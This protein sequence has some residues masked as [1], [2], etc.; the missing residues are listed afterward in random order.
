MIPVLRILIAVLF[1]GIAAWFIRYRYDGSE[2]SV[3]FLAWLVATAVSYALR[4][5]A[6]WVGDMTISRNFCIA[7]FTVLAA[8]LFLIFG[9]ARSFSVDAD[10]TLLFWSLPLMFVMALVI[11][12]PEALF[13]RDGGFWVLKEFN[14]TVTIFVAIYGLYA[15][16]G[17]YYAGMLYRTLRSH[18]QKRELHNFRYILG[19]LLV[20][21]ISAAVG[22]WLKA[23]V[24]SGMPVLEIG[25]L[26]GALLI[27]R[28][29]TGPIE[30]LWL[31]RAQ[32]EL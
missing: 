30:G 31:R 17:L 20:V 29:V 1:G 23:S 6:Y 9:F 28:G 19:G 18:D 12:N 15:L 27:M 2:T 21:F 16:L 3:W 26:I 13:Y 11:M 8:S 25:N 10:Y 22:G 4:V 5:V 24:S 14:A 32:G 7:S